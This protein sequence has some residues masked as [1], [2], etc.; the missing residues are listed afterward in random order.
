MT[1]DNLGPSF[2][3]LQQIIA[4]KHGFYLSRDDPILVLYTMN[5]QL[6]HRNEA[7]VNQ[8]IKNFTEVTEIEAMNWKKEISNTTKNLLQISLEN[9]EKAWE[10]Y[11][12]S[13]L[14][15]VQQEI[16]NYLN[17]QQKIQINILK[18]YKFIGIMN[19]TASL[20][21]LLAV[22]VWVGFVVVL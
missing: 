13:S 11:R 14:S 1:E 17:N 5:E 2:E 12:N 18:E 22:L 21:T 8:A 4:Q 6:L 20:F 16:T 9:H 10:S 19:M 15:Q 7:A 3:E